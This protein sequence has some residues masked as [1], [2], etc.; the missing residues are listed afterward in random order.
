MNALGTHLLLELRECDADK[1]NDLSYVREA[2]IEATERVGATIVGEAFHAFSPHG[3]TGVLAI[4]ESHLCV[5]TWPE[6]GYAAVDIFTCGD[7][8][9]PERAARFLVDRFR[10]RDYEMT[11]VKR[12]VL[13]GAGELAQ[14]AATRDL[15]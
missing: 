12:G 15:A 4:A 13:V 11:E 3:V 9:Q 10:S 2:L 7:A 5:H 8:S 14:T 6:Y 1:L